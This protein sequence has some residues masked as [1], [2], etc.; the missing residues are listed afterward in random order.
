MNEALPTPESYPENRNS[1]AYATPQPSR[2]NPRVSAAAAVLLAGLG[3]I[4]L[5]GCF[6]I[7][8]MEIN[9]SKGFG[10]AAPLTKTSGMI[11]LEIV[12]YLVAFGCFGGAI[13]MFALAVK[14]LRNVT[15]S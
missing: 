6:M 8:I 15:E 1:L 12:L 3:L 5:G 9:Q 4:F 7:G 14:W 10:A 13:F 11:F 2:R